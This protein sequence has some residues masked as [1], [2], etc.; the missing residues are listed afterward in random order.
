MQTSSFQEFNRAL[1]H[2][3]QVV[4]KQRGLSQEAVGEAL[5][6]DRVSIGYIEQGKRAPRLQTVYALA[7]LYQVEVHELFDF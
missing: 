2:H 1:G 5:G 3:L 7:Q 4:R 6:M